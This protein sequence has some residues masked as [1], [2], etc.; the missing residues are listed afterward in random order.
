LARALGAAW[1]L[2]HTAKAVIVPDGEEAVALSPLPV[3]A[4]RLPPTALER[5]EALGLFAI[6]DVLKLPRET[7]ASRFGEI[8]PRRLD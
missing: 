7:L 2:A 6:G 8:L 1:A 5:L 3:S 4:L